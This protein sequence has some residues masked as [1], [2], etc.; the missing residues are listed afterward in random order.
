MIALGVLFSLIVACGQA[1]YVPSSETVTDVHDLAEL[2]EG[3]KLYIKN[4][5]SCH[6]LYPPGKYS[7]L[8]WTNEM[9]EMQKEARITDDQAGLILKYLTGYSD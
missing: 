4:C 8:H 3:R 6:N 7:D 1:L 9:T 5:G 2:T